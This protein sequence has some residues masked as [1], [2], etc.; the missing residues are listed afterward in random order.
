MT[1]VVQNSFSSGEISLTM[2][3]RTDMNK[4]QNGLEICENFFVDFHGGVSNRGGTRHLGRTYSQGYTDN[5]IVKEFQVSARDVY[6]LEFGPLYMRVVRGQGYVTHPSFSI[7]SIAN[8][9]PRVVVTAVGHNFVDGDRVYISNATV[10]TSGSIYIVSNAAINTFEL[11]TED[12]IDF[13]G[14]GFS[15]YTSGGTVAKIF[16][17][18]TPYT[19]DQ[20]L[21]LKFSQSNEVMII[22][23]PEH[24]LK[25]L[26]RIDHHVW[27]LDDKVIGATAIAPATLG[28]VADDTSSPY[29]YAYVVTTVDI[30]GRESGPSEIVRISSN[31]GKPIQLEWSNVTDA[32]Y[33]AV[34]KALPAANASGVPG[35]A[36][37]G[38]IGN[39]LGTAFADTNITPDFSKQPPT[40][41]NPFY[42]SAL[43]AVNVTGAGS[44]YSNP[45]GVISDAGGGTGAT[46]LVFESAGNIRAVQITN[47]GKN[48]VT[49]TLALS[50]AGSGFTYTITIGPDS[51]TYPSVSAFF[52]QRLVLAAS[53]NEPST[54]WGSRVGQFEN[55]D[56]TIPANSGDS[57]TF[58]LSANKINDIK[59]LVAMPGGL[60]IFTGSA[61]WQLSGSGVNSPVLPTNAV[62]NPQ[63]YH[64]ASDLQPIAVDYNILYTQISGITIH[65]LTYNA[66]A[67]NYTTIDLSVFS[68]HLFKY[69]DQSDPIISWAYANT[70]HKAL[71]AIQE[72]GRLLILT[73]MKEQE[74]AGWSKHYTRGNFVSLCV[75]P[76]NGLDI[77]TC[78]THRLINGAWRRSLEQFVPRQMPNGVED[79]WFLDAAA[80]LPMDTFEAY[81]TLSGSSGTVT[82]TTDV[83]VFSAS[84]VGRVLRGGGARGTITAYISP[85]QVTV[86]LLI[87]V[88][89]FIPQTE[90]PQVVKPRTWSITDSVTT[91]YGLMHLEGETVKALADGS[92]VETEVVSGRIT[93]PVAASRVIIGLPYVGYVKPLPLTTNPTTQGRLKRV[94]K[95]TL[96]VS[97][98]RGLK[99]GHFESTLTPIKERAPSTDDP[100]PMFTGDQSQILDPNWAIPG[101]ILI[102]QEN[103][104]PATIL[105][106]A[107]EVE[108]GNS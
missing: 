20:I 5:V 106:I 44:G 93:L 103:P 24:M 88:T 6:V 7:G 55:F 65:E 76:A 53:I 61:V 33:Y 104:L 98:T 85:T 108:L 69:H 54:L 99:V 52:Q 1:N 100:I 48:Y 42:P 83:A 41:R 10:E 46:V 25:E 38:Y 47:G 14:T 39:A 82:A 30:E 80:E 9:S 57:F 22:T 43:V 40:S 72:S 94:V 64:G 17:L 3:G 95:S 4:Y 73:Y 96:R 92:V 71:Y 11:K 19:N 31:P 75:S 36:S 29:K 78:V 8:N 91:V 28:G 56:V 101:Q 15:T 68:T 21:D 35:G 79:G 89:Q 26:T 12:N 58:T 32:A 37:Y 97:D 66:M 16:Q 86:T 49:P 2:Y 23:H 50:G 59:S 62:A 87:P 63:S 13:P 34:Y 105:A 67:Q 77:V 18:T 51:G 60:V 90:I 70:P 84:D 27:S 45:N 102:K 74:L 81:L 107:H